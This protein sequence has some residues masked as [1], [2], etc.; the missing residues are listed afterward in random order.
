MVTT[1]RIWYDFENVGVQQ[2]Y[3]YFHFNFHKF[4]IFTNNH[5]SIISILLNQQ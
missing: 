3:F 1:V 2:Y 4:T 5:I